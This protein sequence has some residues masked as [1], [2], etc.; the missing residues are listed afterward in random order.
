M[1]KHRC[2]RLLNVAHET[3]EQRWEHANLMSRY[4]LQRGETCDQIQRMRPAME[5]ILT[6]TLWIQKRVHFLTIF[7]KSEL[8]TRSPHF[9]LY[10]QLYHSIILTDP[11]SKSPPNQFWLV[12]LIN[13]SLSVW[14]A[15]YIIHRVS[16][17]S[18]RAQVLFF[19]I[20]CHPSLV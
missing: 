8:T 7:N 16:G 17:F 1:C 6:N 9:L 19:I 4:E 15:V 12:K 5:L 10:N 20:W 11:I 3:Y 2:R 14:L 18:V 13:Q